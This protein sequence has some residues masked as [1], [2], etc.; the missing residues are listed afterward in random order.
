LAPTDRL[1]DVESILFLTLRAMAVR[2][3]PAC[4]ATIAPEA[5]AVRG[6]IGSLSVFKQRERTRYRSR[7]LVFRRIYEE[8]EI[9]G[10]RPSGQYIPVETV[11]PPG[12]IG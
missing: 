6:A 12:E 9:L 8:A 4:F 2:G 7:L 10:T 1:L 3:E 5:Q 11:S